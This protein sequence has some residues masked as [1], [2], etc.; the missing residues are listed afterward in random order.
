MNNPKSKNT[1]AVG[2]GQPTTPANNKQTEQAMKDRETVTKLLDDAV[3]AK[4]KAEAYQ[5]ANAMYQWVM[6]DSA[7]TKGK[8]FIESHVTYKHTFGQSVM[9]G[10]GIAVGLF[11]YVAF[12]QFI[13][14]A[15]KFLHL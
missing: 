14:W 3:T 1:N 7:N 8:A 15:L 9:Q 10:F 12:T 11:G 13:S 4:R 2:G 5:L 6:S